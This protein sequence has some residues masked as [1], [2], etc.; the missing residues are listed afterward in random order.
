MLPSFVVVFFLVFLAL[1]LPLDVWDEDPESCEGGQ[2]W[3]QYFF[4]LGHFCHPSLLSLSALMPYPRI[5]SAQL[6]PP[7][8]R[9]PPRQILLSLN[10]LLSCSPSKHIHFVSGGLSYLRDNKSSSELSRKL[11][12]VRVREPVCSPSQRALGF[13]S[14]EPLSYPP[15]LPA[16]SPPQFYYYLFPS[17]HLPFGFPVFNVHQKVPKS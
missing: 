9:T 3:V 5:F 14:H 10:L 2:D 15:G 11:L 17:Q 8:A 1:T 12:S 16:V 4:R 6:R 7:P 13:P